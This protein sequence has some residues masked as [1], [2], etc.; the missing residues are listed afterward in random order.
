MFP[1]KSPRATAILMAGRSEFTEKY[2]EVIE[3]L[4]A[5]SISVAT[6]DWRGQGLSERLLPVREKGHINDFGV[7]RSDFRLFTDYVR[8]RFGGPYI[9][10]THSMGG[11]PVLQ[12]LADGDE[13]FACAVLCAPMTRLF[14]DPVK[15][16]AVRTMAQVASRA[17]F[18]RYSVPGVKEHSLDF[19]GNVLT[20]DRARHKRFHDIQAAGPRACLR[21]P[22]YGWL[23]AATEA[24]DDL[25]RQNRFEKLKTPTLIVS[26]S[27]DKLVSTADHVWLA[28]QSPLIDQITIEGAL[29]E[30]LME[31]DLYRDQYWA[32]F[33][34]FVAQHVAG[35]EATPTT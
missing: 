25:H 14:D 7:F 23:K 16:A 34:K 8:G 30:I 15:R 27:E 6:M 10:M 19:E 29:H 31:R 28:T 32:A 33:D 18:S 12:M 11:L 9:A 5:R 13:R 22:T 24:I 26:A 21:E 1:A 4:L 17:G 3:D 20:S 2:F 35:F